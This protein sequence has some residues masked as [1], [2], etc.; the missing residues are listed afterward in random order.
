[1]RYLQWGV[2][3]RI[4]I[5]AGPPTGCDLIWLQSVSALCA[6]LQHQMLASCIVSQNTAAMQWRIHC[7][8]TKGTTT[9]GDDYMTST[10]LY[11]GGWSLWKCTSKLISFHAPPLQSTEVTQRSHE[12]TKMFGIRP[13]LGW[14]RPRS[15]IDVT[16]A[17]SNVRIIVS[18]DQ[19]PQPTASRNNAVS[20][21]A[22]CACG[23]CDMGGLLVFDVCE[24]RLQST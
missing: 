20:V 12:R 13:L 11:D 24:I 23:R 19:Q 16:V 10:S 6:V 8:V 5:R 22:Q 21:S 17:N 1:M 4:N 2:L 14:M 15:I 3:I 18:W 7:I 9:M